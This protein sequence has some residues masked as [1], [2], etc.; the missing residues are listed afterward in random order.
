MVSRQLEKPENRPDRAVF[1]LRGWQI[2]GLAL[3][4]FVAL[5]IFMTWPVTPN[6]DHSLEQWGD[7]LLQTWTLD[8]DVHA[9]FSN[10]LDFAN[11]NAFYPYH[12]SLAFSETLIG[13]A[14][15]VAPVIWLTDNPVL[16]YNLLLLASFALCGWGMYLLGKDLTHSRVA[17]LGA[18][19]IFGFFPHRFGQLSHLHLLSAQWMPFCLLFLRRFMQSS[20]AL[21]LPGPTLKPLS[22]NPPT[23]AA[24]H[25][26]APD[27]APPSE[28]KPGANAEVTPW[29][30]LRNPPPAKGRPSAG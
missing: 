4:F 13:Q 19:I 12:N 1:N 23:Q 29:R 14:I 16:G 15:L 17:G 21:R 8:W 11:A 2:D 18:G 28:V 20:P 22:E 3:L 6:L 24:A 30:F 25:N 5:A 26:L 27:E 9:L 7:A 10:P